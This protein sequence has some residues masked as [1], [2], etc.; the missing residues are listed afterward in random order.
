MHF[1]NKLPKLAL[2]A[3]AVLALP[4]AAMALQQTTLPQNCA[5]PGG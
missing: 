1:L 4:S 2:Q 3:V 5:G